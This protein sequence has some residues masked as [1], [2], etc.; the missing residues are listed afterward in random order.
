MLQS[1][2]FNHFFS[3][4]MVTCLAS[5]P[6]CGGELIEKFRY[7]MAQMAM[8]D[9]TLNICKDIRYE[10]LRRVVQDTGW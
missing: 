9:K 1:L 4:K 10:N 7:W 8:M 6:N 5:N 2:C 3:Q